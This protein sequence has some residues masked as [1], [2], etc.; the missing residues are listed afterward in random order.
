MSNFQLCF[1]PSTYHK[2]FLFYTLTNCWHTS[3]DITYSYSS[4]WGRP[5]MLQEWGSLV[6]SP[7]TP[8]PRRKGVWWTWAESLSLHWG[9]SM[10]Q[11]DRSSGSVTWQVYHRNAMLLYLL[12][13]PFN[14]T[15]QSDSRFALTLV[16]IICNTA[17]ETSQ[18]KAF[19][20]LIGTCHKTR[21]EDSAKVPF[22][23][24]RWGL[25]MRLEAAMHSLPDHKFTRYSVLF[26]A[27]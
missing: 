14:F 6:S 9:N 21:T 15:D 3:L 5:I 27:S 25:G 18:I 8:P 13:K 2:L 20:G 19:H 12:Y 22:P 10:H 16:A 17:I 11:W 24:C 26:Y 23:P 7:Q 1:S 4:T